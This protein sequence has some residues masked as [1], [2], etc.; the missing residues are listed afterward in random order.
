MS[1]D[2]LAQ[3]GG[4]LAGIGTGV[5]L[6]GSGR[7]LRLV[8]LLA[9]TLGTALVLVRL[10][11]DGH[12]TTLVLA[13]V[14]GICILVVGAAG[15]RRWPWALAFLA[16]AAAPARIPV[17]VGD[18]EANLLVPLYAVIGAGAL[19]LAWSLARDDTEAGELGPLR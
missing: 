17:S 6:V 2:L 19:A 13:A 15:L 9:A 11:P 1:S 7:W 5:V 4:P 3:I 14:V 18:T 12:T 8:G 16:L 10:L